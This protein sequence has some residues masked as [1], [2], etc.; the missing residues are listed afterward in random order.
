MANRLLGTVMLA[1][2]LGAPAL[3]QTPSQPA[4]PQSSPIVQSPVPGAISTAPPVLTPIR[5]LQYSLA[6]IVGPARESRTNG[7]LGS[8]T[9]PDPWTGRSVGASGYE[10]KGSVFVDVLATTQ[11]GGLLVDVS[12][13]ATGRAF[14]KARISVSSDGRLS[15]DAKEQPNVSDEE[16][17]LLRWLAR[18]FYSAD[19]AT[20]PGTSWN[21][22]ANNGGVRS[23]ERYRVISNSGG[24]V[25]LDYKFESMA[26]GYTVTRLG[27]VLY[28][29]RL[30]VPVQVN[31]RGEM[32][33][34]RLGAADTT[35]SS[36]ALSLTADSFNR[37][38]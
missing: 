4:S 24:K 23:S 20:D 33:T 18:G 34:D 31:Y 7:G 27:N 13:T 36:V 9:S 5:T 22:D 21:V 26:N 6:M 32:R 25:N 10:A 8:A 29:T 30:T 17:S 3:A 37:K 19:R 38:G 28:D 1:A 12:E 35:S 11:D 15:Y 2:S 14:P 16:L